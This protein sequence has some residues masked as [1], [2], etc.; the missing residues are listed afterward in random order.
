MNIILV[1]KNQC[2]FLRAYLT[3]FDGR[4]PRQEQVDELHKE[5]NYFALVSHLLWYLWA[6]NQKIISDIDFDY[7]KYGQQRLEEYNKKKMDFL[8]LSHI[9]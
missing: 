8:S 7:E 4:E 6:V 3:E 5:C 2:E 1:M 9:A